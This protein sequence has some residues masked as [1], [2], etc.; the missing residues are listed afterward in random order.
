MI[1]NLEKQEIEKNQVVVD[2]LDLKSLANLQ[3][4]LVGFEMIDETPCLNMRSQTFTHFN[5][6]CNFCLVHFIKL[7]KVKYSSLLL[8]RSGYGHTQKRL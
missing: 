1:S 6:P 7:G 5:Y 4:S 2:P 3:Q 8:I